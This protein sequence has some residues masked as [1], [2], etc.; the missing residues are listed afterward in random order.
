[1][2]KFSRG[3]LLVISFVGKESIVHRDQDNKSKNNNSR[4]CT[5]RPLLCMLHGSYRFSHRNVA[6][7]AS[8][9]S[10]Y[11]C[12]YW[13]ARATT[14][15]CHEDVAEKHGVRFFCQISQQ[16]DALQGISRRPMHSNTINNP[17]DAFIYAR[18]K[19]NTGRGTILLPFWTGG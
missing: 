14:S 17:R 12:S 15:S 8:P 16:L 5:H 3:G 19:K 1:V 10:I 2:Q 9:V 11:T 7:L 13:R 18:E 6:Y 4:R